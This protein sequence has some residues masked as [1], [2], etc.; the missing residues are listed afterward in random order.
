MAR[1]VITHRTTVL[2]VCEQSIGLLSI[3]WEWTY[4]LQRAEAGSG[5]DIS[6]KKFTFHLLR[7][8]FLKSSLINQGF[9]IYGM[10]I[11]FCLFLLVFQF[12]TQFRASP[13][14]LSQN[15]APMQRTPDPL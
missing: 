4:T 6:Q 2:C 8:N 14:P 9:S 1:K 7:K 15:R 11:S 10:L 12:L 3:I 5:A 13:G